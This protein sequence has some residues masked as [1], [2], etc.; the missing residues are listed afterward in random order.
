MKRPRLNFA[1]FPAVDGHSGD[2]AANFCRD[3]LL[4]VLHPNGSNTLPTAKT[5]QDR[6]LKF[7]KL[8]LKVIVYLL[9]GCSSAEPLA[10]SGREDGFRHSRCVRFRY[11][12]GRSKARWQTLG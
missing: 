5:I 3:N 6:V 1:F 8:F 4:A 7:D 10:V 2:E 11:E 12:A 9:I